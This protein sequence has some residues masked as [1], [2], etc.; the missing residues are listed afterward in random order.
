V[1]GDEQPTVPEVHDGP[2]ASQLA[3]G[4]RVGR[5]LVLEVLG[6]G[7]MGVVYAA[8]DP[9]LDRRVAVK[10][11]RDAAGGS[12]GRLRLLR[13]AQAMARVRHPNVVSVFDVGDDFVA[14][15]LVEGETLQQWLATPRSVRDIVTMFVQTGRG[16]A[17]AHEAGVIHRDFKPANVLV[18]KTGQPRVTDFGL[19]RLTGAHDVA[20][21]TPAESTP[22]STDVTRAG[23]IMG[24]PGYISPEQ[25]RAS[26]VDAAS[27][28][29]SFGVAFYRALVGKWPYK[30]DVMKQYFGA[31]RGKTGPAPV[32]PVF[33][34]A[35]M[36]RNVRRVLER[37]LEIDPTRRFPTMRAL[38]VELDR[39]ERTQRRRRV[40]IAGALVTA[41][42]VPTFMLV[43][44]QRA[45]I[46]HIDG[47]AFA[48]AWDPDV[49][50]DVEAAF[51][52]SGKPYAARSAQRVAEVLDAFEASWLATRTSACRA[53]SVSHE[54]SQSELSLENDCLD[55]KL[56]DLRALTRQ[57]V[58]ADATTVER[59]VDAASSLSV[60]ACTNVAALKAIVP[61]PSDEV[62]AKAAKL[63]QRL[64]DVKAMQL[65]GSYPAATAAVHDLESDARQLAYAP[66]L[67]E[68]LLAR[69]Q[70]LA[71]TDDLD[72]AE[73]SLYDAVANADAGRDDQIRA[74]AA[75]E[76]VS[77]LG[78]VRKR[79]DDGERWA[80]FA[81]GTLDRVGD[82]GPLRVR[83]INNRSGI[84]Y[85]QHR[86]KELAPLFEDAIARMDDAFGA[87]RPYRAA[88]MNNLALVYIALGDTTKGVERSRAALALLQR[89]LGSDH[90]DTARGYHTLALALEARGDYKEAL[91]NADLAWQIWSRS[92]PAHHRFAIEGALLAARLRVRAGQPAK[93]VEELEAILALRVA[94]K[95]EDEEVPAIL[96]G[97]GEALLAANRPADA[98]A[99]FEHA[100]ALLRADADPD[101]VESLK[102]GLARANAVG[103]R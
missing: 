43:M 55:R 27:D 102:A 97:I 12:D 73:Q 72:G 93:A 35:R 58:H 25:L 68:V 4:A 69:G 78:Y 18:D 8:Y 64:S 41:L 91:A 11:L 60:T 62:R 14:M 45:A 2:G 99:R 98:R 34:D 20:A 75:I 70:V 22:Q 38:L 40:W 71:R 47:Q 100:Q 13:E 21:E 67:A 19:A 9:Q 36:P 6:E 59:A 86:Y 50:H 74:E 17:T 30:P 95:G 15:E 76:L 63:R 90:P 84:L 32:P 92:L 96:E 26:H 37:A 89:V 94:A 31:H 82:P 46:C 10:L 44:R 33:S 1:G 24:T 81:Q 66:L 48:G 42:A 51:A 79:F 56:E 52:R 85:A 57:L 103:P 16:L 5:F 65:A 49:R 87:D 3:S 80:R 61:P 53:T 29:F 54:R 28:Q 101:L 88:L 7:G 23:T 83:L 77:L 39:G